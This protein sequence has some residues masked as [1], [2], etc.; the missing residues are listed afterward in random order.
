[1]PI[2]H[3][4]AHHSAAQGLCCLALASS[5]ACQGEREFMAVNKVLGPCRRHLSHG[6]GTFV[7]SWYMSLRAHCPST[8]CRVAVS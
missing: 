2:V 5:R 8:A 4:V 3:Y 7:N 1:M 6:C